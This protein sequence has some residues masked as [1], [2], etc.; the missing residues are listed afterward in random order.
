MK[1]ALNCDIHRHMMMEPH[2]RIIFPLDVSSLDDGLRWVDLLEGRVG[3][4]KVGLELFCAVGPDAVRAVAERSGTGV[5]ADL[6]L[7]DIPATVEGAARSLRRIP[8]VDMLTVH[9]SGGRDMLR[10]ARYG[11]GPDIRILAVTR[12]TS[13]AASVEEVAML[14]WHACEEGANGIVCSGIEA[15]AV[16]GAIGSQRT[17]VCPGVR[18]AGAGSGDQVRVVS[19]RD[20]IVAGADYLVVGRPIRDS[21]EPVRAAIAIAAECSEALTVCP[22]DCG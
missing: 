2:Q 12:L 3:L 17:I 7:L 20:A 15:R 10:A 22:N 5:F 19:P 4:F 11:A 18:P 13:Q 16:R 8:G 6:K 21:P 14:A 9:A 1:G